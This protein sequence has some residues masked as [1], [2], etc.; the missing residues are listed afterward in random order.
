[1]TNLKEQM[2]NDSNKALK[3][4]DANKRSALSFLVAE[5]RTAE[6]KKSHVELTDNEVISLLKKQVEQ[7]EKSLFEA[8]RFERTD[9]IEKNKYE[10]NL[11]KTY[12]PTPVSNDD[13]V[14][15]V[16]QVVKDL[17]ATSMRD[18]KNVMAECN[19]RSPGADK[20]TISE[21]AKKLLSSN[22][23]N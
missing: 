13:A 1:M 7:R 2:K 5:I 9:A 4:R 11:I 14:A 10:I 22:A 17:S 3:G 16:E 19:L 12:L 15:I 8:E 23:S 18:M 20:K 6:I 21:H